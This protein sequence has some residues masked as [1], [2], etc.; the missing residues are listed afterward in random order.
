MDMRVSAVSPEL[1]LPAPGEAYYD[2]FVR[3]A[4]NKTAYGLDWSAIAK[5][6]NRENGNDFGECTYRKFFNAFQ[7]GMEYAAQ[8]TGSGPSPAPAAADR[9]LCLSDF[10]YPFQLPVETFSRFRGI[11]TLILNGDL[12]DMQAISRFPKEYRISPMDEM[13][14]ARAY[15]IDLIDHIHPKRVIINKG[16]HEV[17]FGSYLAK[18]MDTELKE[19]MPET[20][21]DLI[22]NDGFH[23]YDKMKRTKVW[24][25]P[26]KTAFDGVTIT[27]TGDWWCK[28]GKT[29]FAHPLAYSSGML[30]TAEKAANYFYRVTSDFDAI[31]LAHTHKLGIYAQGGVTL[32]EQGTCS[33]VEALRYADGQLTNPQ[34]QGFLYLCQDG[35]GRLLFEQSRLISIGQEEQRKEAV[36][37]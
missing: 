28:Y 17:R 33:R 37:L 25:E 10:H 30:K 7:A 27:Y 9:I 2:Y 8:R 23:H 36:L 18:C 34:Q 20:A 21:L 4:T 12:V 32:Y 29:V 14:G 5:L 22:V 35:D 19:L 16:N 31:V 1:L 3:L 11:D 13:I 24:Y 15:L 26:I 6:L